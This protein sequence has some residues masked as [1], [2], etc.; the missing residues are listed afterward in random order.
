MAKGKIPGGITPEHFM[1]IRKHLLN[2][3]RS[4]G[5]STVNMRLNET[6]TAQFAPVFVGWVEEQ[7]LS[8]K[9]AALNIP[10]SGLFRFADSIRSKE[11]SDTVL[12]NGSIV[13]RDWTVQLSE[14]SGDQKKLLPVSGITYQKFIGIM[15]QHENAP[16]CTGALNLGFKGKPSAEAATKAEKVMKDN[17]TGAGSSLIKFLQDN[18]E[19]G[20]IGVNVRGRP[21]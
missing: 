9:R 15:V 19:L 3:L 18:F 17:A 7:A 10:D 13:E 8:E 1:E 12:A 16:H 6:G 21:S 11:Y 4:S 14:K 2:I 20:L 5:A